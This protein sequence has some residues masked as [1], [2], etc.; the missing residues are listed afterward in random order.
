MFAVEAANWS[1][2]EMNQRKIKTI[3]A[4]CVDC[5]TRIIFSILPD[6]GEIVICP[7][8]KIKLE[9]IS[10]SPLKLDWLFEGDDYFY[11][12]LYQRHT[13]P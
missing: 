9:V 8:C 13:Y 3:A 2:K 7:E 5:E 11:D 1:D 6:L 10:L 4:S 12:H